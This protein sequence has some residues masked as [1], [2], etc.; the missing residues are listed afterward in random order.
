MTDSPKPPRSRSRSRSEISADFANLA[1]PQRTSQ[2]E[3]EAHGQR[4]AE[5]RN[6][7]A[8]VTT[9]K[10]AQAL[11][12]A[13][14]QM[15][16][17]LSAVSE[18]LTTR[19][20]QLDTIKE[21][22]SIESEELERLYGARVISEHLDVLIAEHD[23]KKQALDK[24][25]AETRAKWAEERVAAEMART[26]EE[27]EFNYKRTQERKATDDSWKETLR[28]RYIDEENRRLQLEKIWGQREEALKAQESELVDLRAKAQGF[29]AELDKAVK[30][31][32]SVV[33]NRLIKDHTHAMQLLEK[34][35]AG[36]KALYEADKK[37][38]SE[39]LAREQSLTIALRAEL[40]EASKKNTEIATKAL[41]STSSREALTTLQTSL[42]DSGLNGGQKRS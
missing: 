4:A 3:R 33:A 35:R 21:N 31:A 32:E 12:S 27:S 10:A 13:G 42:K 23:E 6:S 39:A 16:K 8:D 9:E 34:D 15:Q 25:V 28:L 38:L 20:A 26:R 24:E 18:E 14:V 40:A 7:I 2:K 1:K 36:E 17:S 41:E 29:Q 11:A 19:I 30:T 5:L 37:S 22:I